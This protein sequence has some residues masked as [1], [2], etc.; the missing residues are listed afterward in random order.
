MSSV[1][2]NY[3]LNLINT[4]SQMLFPL[5]TFPYACRVMGAESI[6]V[7]NFL[8]SIVA[9]VSLFASLGI[10]I[11]AVREVAR[12]RD[13][14]KAMNRAAVEILSLNGLLTLA[15]LAVAAVVCLCVGEVRDNASIFIILCSTIVFNALGCEWLYLGIPSVVQWHGFGIFAGG[16]DN[17]ACYACHCPQTRQAAIG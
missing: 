12:L 13:D 11:Y 5:L 2:K 10:P 8:S 1:T 3:V 4:G 16:G 14:P 9:Y 15:G 6:G 7:V 17:N